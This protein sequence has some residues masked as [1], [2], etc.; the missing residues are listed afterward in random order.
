MGLQLSPYLG[1]NSADKLCQADRSAHDDR[2]AAPASG[3]AGGARHVSWQSSEVGR[4]RVE[5]RLAGNGLQA[6]ATKRRSASSCT[7]T[8]G[9]RD[10]AQGIVIVS[11][12]GYHDIRVREG[13]HGAALTSTLR[14]VHPYPVQCERL[15]ANIQLT[16]LTIEL[17]DAGQEAVKGRGSERVED[18]L[19]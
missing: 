16:C 3:V 19:A 6:A 11:K 15:R 9:A 12:G 14:G 10:R 4:R 2:A 8:E 18:L 17:M 5:G 13:P 1:K 7:R